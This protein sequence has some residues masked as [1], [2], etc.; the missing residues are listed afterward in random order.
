MI[1]N[2]LPP[3]GK[4]YTEAKAKEMVAEERAKW[5]KVIE[6]IKH[7]AKMKATTEEV[8]DEDLYKS[9]LNEDTS[10]DCAMDE[11]IVE[12]EVIILDK[13]FEIIDRKVNEV[14]DG[15]EVHRGN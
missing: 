4:F 9:S 7:E 1:D 8:L 2:S 10:C 14:T 5:L 6:D 15:K 12:T 11:S 3:T 13:L